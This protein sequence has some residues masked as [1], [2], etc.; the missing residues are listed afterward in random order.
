MLLVTRQFLALGH[1]QFLQLLVIAFQRLGLLQGIAV[2]GKHLA[3]GIVELFDARLRG[4]GFGGQALTFIQGCV[5][6]GRRK[7]STGQ[8]QR[9]RQQARRHEGH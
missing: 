5:Q 7:R 6:G 9:N 4:L 1:D 2:F 3:T 8:N